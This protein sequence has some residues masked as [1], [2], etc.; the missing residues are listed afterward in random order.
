MRVSCGNRPKELARAG[1]LRLDRLRPEAGANVGRKL[2]ELE[3]E[4]FRECGRGVLQW[5]WCNWTTCGGPD[6]SE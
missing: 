3:L 6:W 2:L 4:D 5:S 1:Y